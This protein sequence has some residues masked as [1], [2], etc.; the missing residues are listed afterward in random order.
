VVDGTRPLARIEF[1]NAPAT[2]LASDDPAAAVARIRDL[3]SIAHCAEML[4]G[5]RWCVET[6]VEYAK[7]RYQFGR[8]IGSF[9]AVKHRLADMYTRFELA[10]AAV[11]ARHR[12]GRRG[13]PGPARRRGGPRTPR[14]PAR[15]GR[16]PTTRSTSTAG[17]GSPG[18]TTRTCTCAARCRR[19]GCSATPTT[20]TTR[21]ADLLGV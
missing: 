21:L 3:T 17:S 1:D 10:T 14:S 7:I 13:R 4:G 8:A 6:T 15:S 9:Q 5:L 2:K 20:T 18:T 11:R 12:R 19:R 16:P